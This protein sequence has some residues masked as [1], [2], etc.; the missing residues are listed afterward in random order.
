MSEPIVSDIRQQAA[1]RTE[2]PWFYAGYA[3][4]RTRWALRPGN[5]KG[6]LLTLALVAALLATIAEWRLS[7]QAAWVIGGVAVFL[8]VFI[9]IWRRTWLA[10]GRQN[11]PN[12]NW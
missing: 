12:Y 9:Y 6:M 4:R 2:G 10:Q 1:P 8:V 11:P 5:W 3:V 7:G